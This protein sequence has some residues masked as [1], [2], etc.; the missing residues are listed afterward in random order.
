MLMESKMPVMNVNPVCEAPVENTASAEATIL[1]MEADKM[2][3]SR[4]VAGSSEPAAKIS[5]HVESKADL[6]LKK[7]RSSKGATV[8]TL[9]EATGW[10]AHSV[11]GFLSGTVK[12]KLGLTL[13]S[14][15]GKDGV[16][17]YRVA[18]PA[19]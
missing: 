10:Q 5:R 7:L 2:R 3:L 6:V 19:R 14:E 11:R 1:P 15:I 18:N 4:K 8:A 17:R 9:M 16:R 13:A 12:K